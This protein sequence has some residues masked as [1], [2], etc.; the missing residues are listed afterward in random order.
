LRFFS[1]DFSLFEKFTFPSS[2]HA[3]PLRVVQ[4]PTEIFATLCAS[5]VDMIPVVGIS[6]LKLDSFLR[7][8]RFSSCTAG[9]FCAPTLLFFL[10]VA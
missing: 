4:T 9:E 2:L 3:S 1:Y 5:F 6:F 8:N 7:S 10:F